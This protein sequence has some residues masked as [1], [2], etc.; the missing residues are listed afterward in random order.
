MQLA[1]LVLKH[2]R[3]RLIDSNQLPAPVDLASAGFHIENF[4][5]RLRAHRGKISGRES[6]LPFVQDSVLQVSVLVEDLAVLVDRGEFA[7]SRV[8]EIGPKFGHHTQWLDRNLEPSYLCMFDLATDVDHAYVDQLASPHDVWYEDILT[9]THLHDQPPF[10]VV[11]ATGILYHNVEQFRLLAKLWTV[12]RPGALMVLECTVTPMELRLG[13]NE[14]MVELRWHGKRNGSYML[15][16]K[17]AVFTMLAMT[18]WND[19]DWYVD[20]RTVPS[21]LLLTCRR[22]G[23]RPLSH[24]GSAFGIS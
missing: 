11:L 2:M 15:P 18:G 9:E 13:A 4:D 10:D 8:L 24:L 23:E 21:A 14:A 5:L 3:L 22:A 19:I 1:N 20:F 7:K 17:S 12:T 6:D 16:S